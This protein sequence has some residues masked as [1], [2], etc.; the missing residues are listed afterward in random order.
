MVIADE[1]V[2]THYSDT[3]MASLAQADIRAELATFPAGEQSK[4]V[5]QADVLW[6]AAAQAQVDRF[7]MII[8]LGGGVTGDLAGFR[9][10]QLDAWHR[11][12]PDSDQPTGD[13]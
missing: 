10:R 1:T 11:F 6:Q 12:C 4:N 9:R 8:A 5:T 3:V 2:A 13:G 7:G